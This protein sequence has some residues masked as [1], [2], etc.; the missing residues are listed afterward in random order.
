[1]LPYD[2]TDQVTSGVLVDAIA[3]GRPVVATAFPHAVE[4]LS[5]GAGI[6]VGHDD[7]DAMASALRRVLTQP[8][9]AGDMAA[10]ARRLAPE[11]AWPVVASAYLK[12]AHRVLAQRRARV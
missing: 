6:V 2:S 10:E 8:R 7:P 12:V 4:L 11:M 1:V 3:S 5:S 9:L